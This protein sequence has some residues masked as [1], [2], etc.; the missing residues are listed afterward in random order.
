MAGCLFHYKQVLFIFK[1][2]NFY[3]LYLLL[4][5]YLFRFRPLEIDRLLNFPVN[6]EDEQPEL[7]CPVC[8]EVLNP[9]ERP[10]RIFLY[11]NIK[12]F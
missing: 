6:E 7:V 11:Y 5:S 2:Y 4:H 3:P 12:A 1:V 10:N 9:G 8:R